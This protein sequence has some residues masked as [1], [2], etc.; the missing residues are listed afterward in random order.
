[1]RRPSA[2][3]GTKSLIL[4]PREAKFSLQCGGTSLLINSG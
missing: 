4:I 2:E 3:I 1:M